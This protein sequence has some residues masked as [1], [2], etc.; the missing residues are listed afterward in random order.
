M[1][2]VVKTL[3]FKLVTTDMQVVT[4]K[5]GGRVHGLAMESNRLHLGLWKHLRHSTSTSRENSLAAAG[6]I[7]QVD[8]I[9]QKSGYLDFYKESLPQLS[10]LALSS[11]ADAFKVATLSYNSTLCAQSDF[12]KGINWLLK[13]LSDDRIA[14][15]IGKPA[16]YEVRGD[17]ELVKITDD[18][19]IYK[20]DPKV[21]QPKTTD[22]PEGE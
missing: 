16:L 20:P 2:Q 13:A 21:Q 10:G 3:R 11:G 14:R 6:Q 18:E 19:I 8:K 17:F 7:A 5:L 12:V 15:S 22:E 9:R 1:A 4:A